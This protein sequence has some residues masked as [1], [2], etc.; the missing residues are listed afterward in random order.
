[1]A[2]IESICPLCQKEKKL[3]EHH[4]RYYPEEKMLVCENCHQKIHTTP[5]FY[6]NLCP[7][8]YVSGK[9]FRKNKRNRKKRESSKIKNGNNQ[10]IDLPLDLIESMWN[11]G[12]GVTFISDM[13]E[14]SI[15]T[16]IDRLKELDVYEKW[17]YVSEKNVVL[18]EIE[19]KQKIKDM[20]ERDELEIN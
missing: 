17:R 13:M 19:W 4:T 5:R 11:D 7:E 2:K 20:K 8:W 10:K 16:I 6:D 14:C 9:E 12:C 18:V 15:N 3:I 1:M